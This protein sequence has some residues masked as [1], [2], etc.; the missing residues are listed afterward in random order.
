MKRLLLRRGVIGT[1]VAIVAM[2]VSVLTAGSASAT[3]ATYNPLLHA[4]ASH[5]DVVVGCVGGSANWNPGVNPP[6]AQ[7][8]RAAN[9]ASA[10]SDMHAG[11]IEAEVQ[12]QASSAVAYV[13]ENAEAEITDSITVLSAATVD[14]VGTA[15]GHAN[16]DSNIGGR[17]TAKLDAAII[18]PA[19]CGSRDYL[20]SGWDYG[21]SLTSP[22]AFVSGPFDV[23][24]QLQPGTYPIDVWV[25]I[26]AS[27]ETGSGDADVK[28]NL[29]VSSGLVT[30]ASG[31][32][33]IQLAGG[34]PNSP[35]SCQDFAA[36]LLSGN[37]VG[38][39]LACS[40]PDN[41]A[42]IVVIAS[43][44][45][46]GTASITGPD[47]AFSYV[48]NPGFAGTDSFTFQATDSHGAQSNLATAT[49]LVQ[50]TATGQ[51]VQVVPTS[52]VTI[53]FSSVS[54]AGITTATSSTT[55]PAAPAGFVV[56]GLYWNLATTAAFTAPVEVCLAFASTDANPRLYHY[57]N[58]VGV[59]VTSR[60]NGNQVC[61]NVS[62]FSPFVVLSPAYADHFLDP[63]TQTTDP[64]HPVINTGK[65]GRVIPVKVQVSQDG[66]AITGANAPG[67][68]TISVSKLASCSSSATTDP[69]DLYADAGQS[70]AGTNQF[71][72]DAT[73]QSWIYNLDTKA[74]GLVT[75]S[76]YRIDVSV[77]GV[78]VTNPYAVF[79]PTK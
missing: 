23:Q 9:L 52:S 68:I 18:D 14:L 17:A 27:D 24:A 71:R 74:L 35:P 20:C 51:N 42:L 30:S 49:I 72:W 4:A 62:S 44:A 37:G 78:Q 15:T 32:L 3:Y 1:C 38:S 34:Q 61:G 8:Q 26:N 47:G 79:K 16:F 66:T 73:S 39:H 2:M 50:N 40:D 10:L 21:A 19:T 31:L 54:I 29:V 36:S 28:F 69:V 12:A 76:C 53:T 64:S 22:G 67:P 43:P 57:E 5:C 75:G 56:S 33:P 6:P 65:N 13:S 77:N 63:L 58:G 60:I 45:G 59:D 46:N 7:V 41:D 48:P 70:S 25:Q 55:G 11:A